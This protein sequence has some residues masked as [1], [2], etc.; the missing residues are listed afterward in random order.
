[1][2]KEIRR[3]SFIVVCMFLALFVST[4]VIQV[5]QAQSL[6][7]DERNKRTL[8]DSYDVRR[9]P[10]IAGGEQIA[11]STSTSDSYRFQRVYD[12]SEIWAGITGW[13]NPALNSATGIEQSM[14]QEL[15]GLANSGTRLQGRGRRL[16]SEDR[17]DPRARLDARLRRE[18]GRLSRR[19][20]GE[21]G[22]QRLCGRGG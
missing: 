9:G 22:G 1:M 13:F 18:R 2:T 8:Y 6:T 4:S 15:S 3:L 17:A 20:R 16:G 19:H 11:R 10:I 7:A 12:D 14:T 21:R 5:V